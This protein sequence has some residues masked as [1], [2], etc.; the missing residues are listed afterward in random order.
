MLPVY[1]DIHIHTSENPNCL[2]QTYNVAELRKRI[3]GLQLYM[4]LF[5]LRQDYCWEGGKYWDI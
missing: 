2:E 1:V 3:T 5:L 4:L